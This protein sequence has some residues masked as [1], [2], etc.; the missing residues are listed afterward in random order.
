MAPAT[1]RASLGDSSPAKVGRPSKRPRKVNLVPVVVNALEQADV[2]PADLRTVFTSALPLVLNANKADRH[3]YENEVVAQAEK[4]LAVVQADLEQ[5]HAVA[6]QNQNALIAP[7]EHAKRSSDQEAAEAACKAISEKLEANKETQFGAR[8]S[9]H[10]AQTALKLAQK[11]AASSEKEMQALADKKTNLSELLEKEFQLVQETTTATP[12]G[13]EAV[14]KLSKVGKEFKFDETLL[15]TLPHTC[16]KEL[17]NRTEFEV[18]MFATLK[19]NI[20]RQIDGFTQKLAEMEPS[21]AEKLSAVA[22]AQNVVEKAEVALA[23]ASE[24]LSASAAGTKE[25]TKEKAK[26]DEHFYQIWGDMKVVCDLQDGLAR[27]VKNFKETVA[28]AFQQ[29]K[30]REPEPEEPE[31]VEAEHAE[32]EAAEEE[33]EAEAAV[34]EAAH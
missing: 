18:I 16:K 11:D 25:A 19:T 27:E 22:S 23:A 8:R 15:Q 31:H 29:L 30:E 7:A 1:K 20:D 33:Q 26:A 14:K 5:K 3:G 28:A 10:D 4:A 13:K 2:L 21:K 17:A 34:E 6:L 9:V 12:E 32:E 24:V